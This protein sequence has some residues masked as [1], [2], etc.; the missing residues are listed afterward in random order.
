MRK[1]NGANHDRPDQTSY[2]IAHER[3]PQR[4][5]RSEDPGTVQGTAMRLAAKR[6]NRLTRF[7]RTT[8]VERCLMPQ[9]RRR[10]DW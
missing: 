3:G 9:N 6:L 8:G 7:A 4:F 5:G 10:V 1:D 2:T